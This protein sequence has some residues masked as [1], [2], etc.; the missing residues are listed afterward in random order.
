ML[1]IIFFTLLPSSIFILVWLTSHVAI[2]EKQG[3]IYCLH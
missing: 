3:Q 2:K 1:V